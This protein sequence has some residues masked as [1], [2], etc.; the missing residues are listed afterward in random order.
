[1][2]WVEGMNSAHAALAKELDCKTIETPELAFLVAEFAR[3]IIG[4]PPTFKSNKFL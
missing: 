4:H 2:E 3:V 1:M